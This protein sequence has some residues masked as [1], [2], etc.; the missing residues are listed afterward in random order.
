[1]GQ[2]ENQ[3]RIWLVAQWSIAESVRDHGGHISS[4]LRRP[5]SFVPPQGALGASWLSYL[6]HE[7]LRNLWFPSCLRVFVA[8]SFENLQILPLDFSTPFFGLEMRVLKKC[9]KTTNFRQFAL[10]FWQKVAKPRLFAMRGLHSCRYRPARKCA[11]SQYP[12]MP[13]RYP[14]FRLEY[15]DSP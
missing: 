14:P 3:G 12:N 1:M 9:P 7:N 5:S 15:A 13:E 4:V 6:M 2:P 10:S 8:K 11:P